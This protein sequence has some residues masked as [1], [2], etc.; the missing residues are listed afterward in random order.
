MPTSTGWSQMLGKNQSVQS[1]DPAASAGRVEGH[2]V[3]A[4]L[5]EPGLAVERQVWRSGN[6]GSLAGSAGGS[7]PILVRRQLSGE[8]PRHR[9]GGRGCA[10][11]L[12]G[13]SC[14]SQWHSSNHWTLIFPPQN[15]LVAASHE[16][17]G[18]SV[19]NV[20]AGHEVRARSAAANSSPRL[21]RCGTTRLM[22]GTTHIARVL[23]SSSRYQRRPR[24]SIVS[25]V[26]R[27]VGLSRHGST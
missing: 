23:L 10:L 15:A 3:P 27:G 6:R 7:G 22:K 1:H 14:G 11:G 26:N 4:G 20:R 17:F 13:E 5:P 16:R 18:I 24:L 2:A 8:L 19:R 25:A 21:D 12:A 9:Q